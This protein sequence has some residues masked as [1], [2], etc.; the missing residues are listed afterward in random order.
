MSEILKTV[1]RSPVG[2]GVKSI[3]GHKV[4]DKCHIFQNCV[5]FLFFVFLNRPRECPQVLVLV[6][7]LA[8]KRPTLVQLVL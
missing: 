5:L 7:A 1:F 2:V 8:L 3:F 6:L 4:K